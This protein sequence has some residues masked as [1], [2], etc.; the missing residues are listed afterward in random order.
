MLKSKRTP[1]AT[2]RQRI[3]FLSK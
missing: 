2:T 3:A 1:S